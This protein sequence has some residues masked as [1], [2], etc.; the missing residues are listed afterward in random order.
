MGEPSR[1]PWFEDLLARYHD[2]LVWFVRGLLDDEQN[3]RDIAQETFLAAWLARQQRAAPFTTV[4]D[5]I[6]IR[7]WLYSVAYNRAMSF[8]RQRRRRGWDSYEQLVVV[9]EGVFSQPTSFEDQVA[10]SD[11]LRAALAQ[12][13]PEDAAAVLPHVVH[14]FTAAEIALILDVSLAAATK[15]VWRA[16]ERLRAAYFSAQPRHAPVQE[17]EA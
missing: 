13:S 8:L 5:E 15:R 6:G 3:A 9:E 7:R 11:A 4:T 1:D 2:R 17:R 14:G 10:E 16:K 12:L